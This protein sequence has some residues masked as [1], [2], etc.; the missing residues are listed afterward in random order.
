MREL[1]ITL[2]RNSPVPLYHQLAQAIEHAISTGILSPGDRLENELSLT[3]RLGLSRPIH[4]KKRRRASCA[5]A[6]AMPSP[7]ATLPAP[8]TRG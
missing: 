6:V 3:S 7:L 4:R 1:D 2:D 8:F 5:D